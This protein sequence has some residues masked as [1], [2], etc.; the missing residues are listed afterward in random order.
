VPARRYAVFE[1]RGHVSTIY[2]TYAQIW[3]VAMPAL[4]RSVADAPV[5]ERHNDAFDPEPAKVACRCGSPGGVT[6]APE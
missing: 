6:R 4:G 1:H 5:I 3:N 2:E